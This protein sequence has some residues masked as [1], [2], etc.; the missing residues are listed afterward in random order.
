[1]ATATTDLET[2]TAEE[3]IAYAVERFHPRLTMACS[4]QKEESVLVHMLTRI[5]PAA[6]VFTIDTGV[7]F[8]ETLTAWKAF[9]DR[10]GLLVEVF[11]ARSETTPW[12]GRGHCCSASGPGGNPP[13]VDA[14]AQALSGV[15]AWITGIRR[16]QAPTRAGAPKL[17]RDE[18]RG[19]WKVNPLADW[20]DKDVWRYIHRHDLP[21]H[22]LHDHGYSSIGCAPC[23][24]P[25]SGREGRWAGEDKTE[26]GLHV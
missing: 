26:C 9:E 16:E 1:M 5:E 24:R 6:R 12:T 15:A 18:A 4:F 22:Q 8:P 19:I 2:A 25:G 7:L 14:L 21:Y 3:V 11:E 23:T 20:T 13:K 17:E 10:F